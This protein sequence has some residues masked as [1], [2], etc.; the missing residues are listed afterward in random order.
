LEGLIIHAVCVDM[1]SGAELKERCQGRAMSV[2]PQASDSHISIS[3][4]HITL[5]KLTRDVLYTCMQFMQTC[6]WT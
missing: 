1:R 5:S 3:T 4:C 6:S 2:T